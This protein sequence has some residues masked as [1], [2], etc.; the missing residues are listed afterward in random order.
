MHYDCSKFRKWM[1]ESYEPSEENRVLTKIRDDAPREAREAYENYLEALFNFNTDG[2][3]DI[4]ESLDDYKPY[5]NKQKVFPVSVENEIYYQ[6]S[7]EYEIR[8]QKKNFKYFLKELERI[9]VKY[10][11]INPDNLPLD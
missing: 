11:I 7:N 6:K 9:G 10:E 3:I 8:A 2:V 1:D 5:L 4:I